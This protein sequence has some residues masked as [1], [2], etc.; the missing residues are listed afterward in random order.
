MAS[1]QVVETLVN[2][3]NSPS[4]D[5]T[6]NPDE[7]SNH[8]IYSPGFKPIT[9]ISNSSSTSSSGGGGCNS[10]LVFMENIWIFGK[11]CFSLTESNIQISYI[12]DVHDYSFFSF[13]EQDSAG[14]NSLT[15]NPPSEQR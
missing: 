11:S 7:H 3:K 8:N 5:Y 4:Q 1:A 2:T 6:T 12:E 13:L 10:I 15:V 9:V 14:C